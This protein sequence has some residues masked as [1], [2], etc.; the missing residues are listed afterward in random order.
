MAT[1][2]YFAGENV[3]VTVVE[4]PAQVAEAFESAN[5]FPFRLTGHDAGEVYV[6]PTTVAFWS[7]SGSSAEPEPSPES[8]QPKTKREPVTNIWGQPIHTKPRR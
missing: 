1:E 8:P 5:G 2:I 4:D 3:R 7:D 6:N